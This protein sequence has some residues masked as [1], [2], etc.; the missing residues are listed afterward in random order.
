MTGEGADEIFGYDRIFRWALKQKF[1]FNKFIQ[2]YSYSK[3]IKP[4]K[5]LKEEILNLKGKKK[6]INFIEDF[7]M[8][9]IF[10]SSLEEWTVS[11]A[12]SKEASNFVTKKIT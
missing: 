5:R 8:I 6:V 7:F 11:M 10:L 2:F 4:T 3:T 9:F 12:A 1:N